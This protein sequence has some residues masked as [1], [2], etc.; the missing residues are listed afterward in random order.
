MTKL[1]GTS[2]TD[3]TFFADLAKL[4]TDR[5]AQTAELDKPLGDGSTLRETLE[6][7]QRMYGI[8]DPRLIERPLTYL[9]SP[10]WNTFWTLHETRQMTQFG[11]YQPICYQEIKAYSE[12]MDVTFEPYEIEIIKRM[13][14]AF[15]KAINIKNG[16]K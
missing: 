15:L 8:R 1:R 6:F 16:D 10:L 14:R 3:K 12:L 11:G 4:L 7:Q 9:S 2:L 13:D 5:V